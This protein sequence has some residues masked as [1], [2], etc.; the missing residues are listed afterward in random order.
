LALEVPLAQTGPSPAS[1]EEKDQ[2]EKNI[3]NYRRQ[4]ADETATSKKPAS[5]PK[6]CAKLAGYEAQ[7]ADRVRCTDYPM[8]PETADVVRRAWR[9]ISAPA[10]LPP[11]PVFP[12]I[13]RR[14][15]SLSR[16]NPVIAGVELLP[17]IYDKCTVLKQS[18]DKAVVGDVIAQVHGNAR[19]Y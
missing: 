17:L 8:N 16:G 4:L 2:L 14:A 19:R 12:P 18:G 9:K 5:D 7:L 15:A 10:T 13:A 3:A 6:T 1:G 11:R